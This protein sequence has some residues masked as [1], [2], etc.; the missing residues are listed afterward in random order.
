M[1]L[2]RFMPPMFLFKKWNCFNL[3]VERIMNRGFVLSKK[4]FPSELTKDNFGLGIK[5]RSP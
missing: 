4:G 5:I 2:I 1:V 3:V